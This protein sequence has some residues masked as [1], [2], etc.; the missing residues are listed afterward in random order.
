MTGGTTT[1][2]GKS[3]PGD[4]RAATEPAHDGRDDGSQK[5]GHLICGNVRLREQ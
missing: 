2:I 1:T 5:T 4:L 3:A